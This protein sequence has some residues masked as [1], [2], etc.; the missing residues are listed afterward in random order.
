MMPTCDQ[1]GRRKRWEGREGAERPGQH[2]GLGCDSGS[3]DRDRI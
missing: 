2:L 1:W 3:L